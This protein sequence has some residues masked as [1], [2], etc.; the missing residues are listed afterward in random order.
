MPLREELRRDGDWLFRRRG[1]LPVIMLGVFLLAMR[2]FHYPWQSRLLEQFW[3][4]ACLL[5][6]FTGLGIR[7][8]TIAHVP[9]NTSGR[10]TRGQKAGRLNTSGIYSIVRHPLYVG[11]FFMWLGLA[12]F[13]RQPWVIFF[14]VL[15]FWIYYERIMYSEEEFLRETFPDAFP[16]WGG[17]TPAV[18]PDFSLYRRPELPFSLRNVLRREYNGFFVLVTVFYVFEVL[19]DYLVQG[20]WQAG[21]VWTAFLICSAVIWVVLRTLKK[22]TRLLKVSGR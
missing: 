4:A 19:G 20:H 6:S 18:I 17:R 8:F 14:Y 22:T 7:V 12:M 11:N 3:E 16:E 1:W 5:V 13:P 21:R 9:A 2:N 15:V 10:N